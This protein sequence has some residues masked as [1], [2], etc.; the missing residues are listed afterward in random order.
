M[1]I[2]KKCFK[3]TFQILDYIIIIFGEIFNFGKRPLLMV[4]VFPDDFL[5]DDLFSEIYLGDVQISTWPSGRAR[6]TLENSSSG[7]QPL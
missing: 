6:A 2:I 3:L 7:D 1:S 5:S 4:D